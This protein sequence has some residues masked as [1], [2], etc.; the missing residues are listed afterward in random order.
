MNKNVLIVLGILVPLFSYSK[1]LEVNGIWELAKREV[2]IEAN[3]V[4]QVKD[5][6]KRNL[7]FCNDT[8]LQS[9]L[10][11]IS[12]TVCTMVCSHFRKEKTNRNT[13]LYKA[14]FNRIKANGIK[15]NV[16]KGRNDFRVKELKVI[17]SLVCSKF[18]VFDKYEFL[19][20][21]LYSKRIYP[22]YNDYGERMV[23]VYF[24]IRRKTSP[25]EYLNYPFSLPAIINIDKKSVE[26]F[27][28]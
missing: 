5:S 10:N 2:V 7:S 22:F 16:L 11:I 13:F 18:P 1:S 15:N 12:D 21:S 27:D 8:S 28:W 6:L 25:H 20:Y 14:F 3:D 17:D 26:D 23:V 9:H 19:I 24:Y 4:V